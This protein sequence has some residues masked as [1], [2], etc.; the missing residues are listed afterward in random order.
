MKFST[1]IRTTKSVNFRAAVLRQQFVPSPKA[2][3]Q[4]SRSLTITITHTAKKV[5][6]GLTLVTNAEGERG[7]LLRESCQRVR[8]IGLKGLCWLAENNKG[9]QP[10]EKKWD[11]LSKACTSQSAVKSKQATILYKREQGHIASIG[12]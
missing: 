10:H 2:K 4:A 3:I 12:T 9:K 7:E 6:E 5:E 1:R 11:E 8:R